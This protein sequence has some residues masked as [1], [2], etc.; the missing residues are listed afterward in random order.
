MDTGIVPD[1]PH[2]TYRTVIL[3][4][5]NPKGYWMSAYYVDNIAAISGTSR[6]SEG[7]LFLSFVIPNIHRAHYSESLN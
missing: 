6:Y 4:G 5:S 2:A 7:S 1:T 3:N